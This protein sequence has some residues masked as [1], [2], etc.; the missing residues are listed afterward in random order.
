M[1][2]PFIRD[3]VIIGWPNKGVNKG[4]K[5]KRFHITAT[6]LDAGRPASAEEQ[7]RI[8]LDLLTTR[9][10]FEAHTQQRLVDAYRLK[11]VKPGTL[12][13]RLRRVL[14]DCAANPAAETQKDEHGRPLCRFGELRRDGSMS[15]RGS[16]TMATLVNQ[17]TTMI[18]L[19]RAHR[20]I[21][22]DTGLD[23]F[24]VWDLDYGGRAG[25]LVDLLPEQLGLRLVPAR[26]PVDVVLIDQVQLP[27]P[28]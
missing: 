4:I 6:L 18:N 5:D 14:F 13:P 27:T 21:V 12:G 7:R 8:I 20:V 24:F 28:N 25:R 17:L 19:G 22:D 26:V 16:G 15:R 2:S 10:G 1:V 9:F 3:K 11:P 23:G